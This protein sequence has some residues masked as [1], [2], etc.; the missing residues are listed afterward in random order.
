MPTQIDLL[1]LSITVLAPTLF[2]AGYHYYRD[3]R[4][5]EPWPHTLLAFVAGIAAGWFGQVLYH[6]LGV[7]GLWFDP[8]QLAAGHPLGLLLYSLLGI[9]LVEELAKLLP[10]LLI[11][12]W[13]P[14]FDEPVDGIIYAAFIALGFASYENFYY[15]E[16]LS[17]QEQ[18]ARG[19]SSPLIHCLFASLWGYPLG[20]AIVAGQ[21]LGIPLTKGLGAAV[22]VHGIYDFLVF[23]MAMWPRL[24]AATV[25]LAVWLWRMHLMERVLPAQQP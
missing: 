25:I 9:A 14:A 12:R 21:P 3:R 2:W 19:L 18:L 17:P 23:G 7:L 8:Y 13:L 1:A 16:F 6:G 20:R 15:L 11:I 5:P 24:L 4:Q 10:F 22:F